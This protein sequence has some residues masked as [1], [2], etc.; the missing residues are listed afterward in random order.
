MRFYWVDVFAEEKYQG[1][2]L[3]V[4][5][6]ERE[7][8]TEEMQCIAREV[9]LSETAFILSDRQAN[10]GYHVRIFTPDEEVPFA[11]HPTLGTAY[12]IRRILEQSAGDRVLLN[13]K[14]GPIPVNFTGEDGQELTM[15]QNQPVFGPVLPPEPMLEILHLAEE[16]LDPSFPVQA[17]STGL[18]SVMVPLRSL[19]AVRRCV[20]D[21][22]KYQTFL[23]EVTKANLLV[24]TPETVHEE[25]DLHVRVFVS[26][27]G[28]AEDP[29]TG[30]ANGNLAGYLLEHR[31]FG[32][33]SIRLRVEQGYKMKRPSL[34]TIDAIK[35]D[36]TF[37]IRVG[38]KVFYVAK[39][40]WL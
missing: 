27:A 33:S 19:D 17:V 18:P 37:Q 26:D 16:D 5:I 36:K 20:V 7:I 24:F 40:E 12:I 10:G 25:N 14:V 6:P 21:H 1:N 30:S 39:G 29:A 15:K 31:T 34:I 28:F 4:F 22:R 3:A 2:Q 8:S 32:G 9:R 13:L 11:G 38:G 35:Q 23:N